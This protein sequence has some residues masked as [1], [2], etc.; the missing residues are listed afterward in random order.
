MLE[1]RGLHHASCPDTEAR[2]MRLRGHDHEITSET[3]IVLSIH[4]EIA[5]HKQN[6]WIWA[7]SD[8]SKPFFLLATTCYFLAANIGHTKVLCKPLAGTSPKLVP[9]AEANC[10]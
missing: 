4:L 2:Y 7:L 5:D 3:L 8:E 10:W 1:C 9:T 6:D